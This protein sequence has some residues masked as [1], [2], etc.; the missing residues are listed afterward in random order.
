MSEYTEKHTVA[1]LIGRL[2]DMWVRRTAVCWPM[3][4]ARHPTALLLDEIERLIRTST[5]SCCRWWTMR[6]DR[7]QR[8]SCRF[9]QRDIDG[10]EQC[11]STVR[12]TGECG[13]QRKHIPWRG[14]AGTGEENFQARIH[15]PSLWY[16]GLPWYGPHDGVTHPRQ[17][18][19]ELQEKLTAKKVIMHLSDA[20]RELLLTK[21]FTREYG[22]R[23]MDRIIA[24]MLKPL[25]MHEILFGKL[26]KGGIMAE[27]EVMN[28]LKLIVKDWS[29]V[30]L[31]RGVSHTPQLRKWFSN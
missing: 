23:E 7:Q 5:T 21:G 14:D 10:D 30:F 24:T 13:L 3:L 31:C 4:S 19:G 22:A 12:F 18:L 2:P 26:K 27:I 16:G 1:K 8:S 20:A 6:D 29:E 28:D 17:K 15:Q 9:P 25:L 11:R